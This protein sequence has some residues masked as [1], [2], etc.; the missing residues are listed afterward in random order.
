[1]DKNKKMNHIGMIVLISLFFIFF[2]ITSIFLEK[3]DLKG[4]EVE[5][6]V[7]PEINTNNYEYQKGVISSLYDNI[8]VLYD[9]V[10]NKF[11]VSQEDVI[12][13]G[14]ITYKKI[15]NFD[16][17]MNNY[18]TE[19]GINKYISD[20]GNFFAYNE[21]GYYLAGNLVSYQTYYFRGDNTNIYILD[22]TSEEI[23]GIIYEKWK[24]NNKNTLATIKVV[25]DSNNKW[26]ID[27]IT[28]LSSE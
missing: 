6:T 27:D 24:S 25:K 16:E 2:I 4:N 23:N 12:N 14:D 10:N 13:I 11:K 22:A 5:N 19:N 3:R 21:N 7:L 9:V 18:F 1:M 28:I 8:R 26:L 15:L 20:M 17:I